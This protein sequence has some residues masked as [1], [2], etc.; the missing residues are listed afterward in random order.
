MSITRAMQFIAA[1]ALVHRASA[2]RRLALAPT[3]LASSVRTGRAV[4]AMAEPDEEQRRFAE[5]QKT[6]AKLPAE[7]EAR[8]LVAYSTGWA[9]ISTN[10]REDEG[11]PNGGLVAFAPG[12]DGLPVFFFSSMSQH[13]K[14][15]NTSPKASLT[16][17]AAGFDGA[18]S[19]RINLMGDVVP[20]QGEAEVAA[21]REAYL[22]KHKDAFWINFGD[23]QVRRQRARRA[24]A[25][26]ARRRASSRARW[27]VV[28][29]CAWAA[30]ASAGSMALASPGR[31]RSACLSARSPATTR[32]RIPNDRYPPA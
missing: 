5:H 23:F 14:D 2:F 27:L 11:Y 22:A 31:T 12:A 6:A 28:V 15:L 30:R 10:S 9:V 21:A 25:V 17:T 16:V 4:V 26:R 32:R 7:V 1:A 20:V 24:H 29:S 18:D 13:T 19:G 3:R 8:S